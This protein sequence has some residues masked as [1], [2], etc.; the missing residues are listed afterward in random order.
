MHWPQQDGMLHN[1]TPMRRITLFTSIIVLC[2]NPKVNAQVETCIRQNDSLQ[3]TRIIN[4]FFDWYISSIKNHK[5]SEYQPIFSQH[6][7]G[8]ATLDFSN[9]FQNLRKL[10]FSETLI[11]RERKQYQVCIDS[12]ERIKYSVFVKEYTDLDDFERISCD[13]SNYYRWTG[14]MDPIDGITINSVTFDENLNALL[15]GQF[16]F[17]NAAT[18]QP[19]Y[20]GKFYAKLIKEGKK[21]VIL[22]IE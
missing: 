1:I 21:W 3:V 8:M 7:N 11:E 9:Y 22:S 12:L 5:Y 16:Y 4:N 15:K 18:E 14:G 6:K 10:S 17:K 20:A 13:F 2:I 19:N